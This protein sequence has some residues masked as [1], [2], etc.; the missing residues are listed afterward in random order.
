VEL[1][2]RALFEYPSV[3]GLALQVENSLR[4]GTGWRRR[5]WWE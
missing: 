2:L 3:A 4:A 1:P 5:R